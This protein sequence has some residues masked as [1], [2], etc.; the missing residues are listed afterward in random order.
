VGK[1][2]CSKPELGR[3]K[4]LGRIPVVF[5]PAC[6]QQELRQGRLTPSY[7]RIP[8]HIGG[9]C[10]DEG[11]SLF[12][13]ALIYVS[14]NDFNFWTDEKLLGTHL[15]LSVKIARNNLLPV[16]ERI[17]IF[18]DGQEFLPG[19]QAM[20]TPVTRKSTPASS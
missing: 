20:F 2:F 17:V 19:V 7:V 1:G 11:V 15:D 16:L 10:T 9:I 8:T 5:R 6:E 14:E 18:K 3:S 12:P 13:N 4:C